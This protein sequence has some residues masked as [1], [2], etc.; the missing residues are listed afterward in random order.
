VVRLL[1]ELVLVCWQRP[2]GMQLSLGNSLASL[3][4]LRMP[5]GGND[6]VSATDGE[7][8]LPL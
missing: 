1:C 6:S 4:V 3:V 7:S 2:L 8:K 5:G